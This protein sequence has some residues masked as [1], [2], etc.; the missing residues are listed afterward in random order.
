MPAPPTGQLIHL[1]AFPSRLVAPRPVDVW[2]PPEYDQQ[3]NA[4]FPVLYMHDGQN[5][6]DPALAFTGIDWGVDE[7]LQ[8][9]VETG[10][11]APRIVVAIWNVEKR[12]LEYIPHRPLQTPAGAAY[13]QAALAKY[14]GADNQVVSERYLRFLVEELKPFVDRTFR[15]QPG[16]A[17]TAIAGSSMGGLVS[18][19][20]LCEYPGVFQAAG[21]LSTHWPALGPAG[22]E[23][24]AEALPPPGAHRLYFDYGDQG[25]DAEYEP[26]Q[27][28]ADALLEQYGYTKNV[29]WL[30]LKFP[31]AEHNE[32]AWRAR[33]D[34]VF[35]FLLK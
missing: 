11:I 23:W 35:Q 8:R 28:Q 15:S 31:G 5:L 34:Q 2:L 25:L 20:A 18:L 4:R 3:P 24:L 33:L 13:R 17:Q 26:Y 19:A 29:D 12:W 9:L 22:I 7:A 10:L 30:T 16:P 1:P 21:C 14:P 27:L 6:F 32:A